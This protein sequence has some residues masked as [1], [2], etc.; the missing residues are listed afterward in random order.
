M[1]A[2]PGRNLRVWVREQ[3]PSVGPW[4][5]Q[6]AAFCSTAPGPAVSRA[7]VEVAAREFIEKKVSP[8]VPVITPAAR[9]LVNFPN[10]VSAVAA[11]PVQFDIT[12]PLPGHIEAF[13]AY[14][15]TFTDSQGVPGTATG[16]GRRYDGTSPRVPGYYLTATF[17]H[18]GAATV[19]LRSTWTATVTVQNQ[20]AVT[21][22]PIVFQ[23]TVGVQVE[24][25]RP[26][27]LDPYGE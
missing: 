5:L 6:A 8:G 10:I 27:L 26:V 7:Q 25:L 23:N 15:W 13:P 4:Q 1:V 14:E 22:A 11:G 3:T 2:T 18:S 19:T 17:R 12:V 24:Q 21:L 20:P 16:T 9:T